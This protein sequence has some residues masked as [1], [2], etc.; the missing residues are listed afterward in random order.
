MWSRTKVKKVASFKY[1]FI[2]SFHSYGGIDSTGGQILCSLSS[3]IKLIRLLIYINS[4]SQNIYS[5]KATCLTEKFEAENTGIIL[6]VLGP[7]FKIKFSI[8]FEE[9]SLQRRKS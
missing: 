8:V 2:L 1:K 7:F 6:K 4:H 9:L 5:W 3:D